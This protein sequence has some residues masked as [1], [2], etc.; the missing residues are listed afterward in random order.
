MET[1][2]TREGKKKKTKK[3]KP[4]SCC[5]SLRGRG[6]KECIHWR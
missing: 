6:R 5:S 1:K 3:K 2:K 4:F